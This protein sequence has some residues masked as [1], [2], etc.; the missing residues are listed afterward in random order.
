MSFD[1]LHDPVPWA[2]AEMVCYKVVRLAPRS[3]FV[4]GDPDGRV[5]ATIEN[6]LSDP[7]VEWHCNYFDALVDELVPGF[8]CGIWLGDGK[9]SYQ[10]SWSEICELGQNSLESILCAEPIVRGYG[11]GLANLRA[12]DSDL[13]RISTDEI[14]DGCGGT[15][16][17]E[18]WEEKCQW[19]VAE[20]A[21]WRFELDAESRRNE[22]VKKLPELD[23]HEI[24]RECESILQQWPHAHEV[25]TM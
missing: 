18:T 23:V 7:E 22:F 17:R 15:R 25:L 10:E 3:V 12:L 8:H 13:M 20:I 1:T 19:A 2:V 6:L 11:V 16:V 24:G 14:P 5:G 21:A 4:V 9:L